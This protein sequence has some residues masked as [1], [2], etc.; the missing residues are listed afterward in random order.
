MDNK[1]NIQRIANEFVLRNELVYPLRVETLLR[2]CE[3]LGIKVNSYNRARAKIEKYHLEAYT[4]SYDAFT[5]IGEES[6]MIFFKDELAYGDKIFTI[7]HEIGHIELF[8]T[9]NGIMGKSEDKEEEDL[10]EKEADIFAYYVAAPL[11]L[12]RNKRAYSPERIQALTLLEKEQAKA[13]SEM[14]SENTDT[15]DELEQKILKQNARRKIKSSSL[16]IFVIICFVFSAGILTFVLA[17]ASR[18]S[19]IVSDPAGISSEQQNVSVAAPVDPSSSEAPPAG[20][21]TGDMVYISVS[22]SKYHFPG[23]QYINGNMVRVTLSEAVRQG[24]GPCKRCGKEE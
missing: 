24:Y 2:L 20:E 14:I 5:I 6:S 11:C 12:L 17:D 22:G 21:E 23:C 13:V 1:K 16:W 18:E 10:Q 7:L 4:E 9:F 19:R 15:N 8:H 3:K